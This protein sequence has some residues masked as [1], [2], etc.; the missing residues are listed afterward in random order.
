MIKW[1]MFARTQSKLSLLDL[2]AEIMGCRRWTK[3]DKKGCSYRGI[4][5]SIST[6]IASAVEMERR[7]VRMVM[8]TPINILVIVSH[9]FDMRNLPYSI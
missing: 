8:T 5:E 7:R 4:L 1:Q 3:L 9:P 6:S 2:R